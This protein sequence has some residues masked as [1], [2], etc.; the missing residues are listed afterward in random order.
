M[1]VAIVLR[2]PLCGGGHCVE[3]AIVWRWPLC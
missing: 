2:W 1:E 3:V